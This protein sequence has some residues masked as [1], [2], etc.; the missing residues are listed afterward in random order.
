MRYELS[1]LMPNLNIEE[2]ENFLAKIEQEIKKL[3]GKV[4]DKFIEKKFF[5]YPIKKQTEGFFGQLNF[6]M[7]TN[8]IEKFHSFLKLN[9]NILREIIERTKERKED[10]KTAPRERKEKPHLQIK[11]PLIKKEKVKIEKLDE[12]LDEIL[13]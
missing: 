9:N 7:E 11:K 13:K 4:E 8:Q 5:A 6:S 2:R 1:F 10:S 12:K 3:K